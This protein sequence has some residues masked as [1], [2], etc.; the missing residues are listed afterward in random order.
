MSTEQQQ[1]EATIAADARRVLEPIEVPSPLADLWEELREVMAALDRGTWFS[2]TLDLVRADGSAAFSYNHDE[3]IRF[4]RLIPELDPA[5][6]DLTS[7]LDESWADELRRHP[8]SPAYVPAWLRE[9][10]G[11]EAVARGSGQDGRGTTPEP[12]VHRTTRTVLPKQEQIEATIAAEARR[13]LEQREWTTARFTVARVGGEG[14]SVGRCTRPDG[15][16]EAIRLRM[17]FRDLWE[18]L[19][20]VM[21][22][23]D[24]GTWFSATLDLDRA[25][26]S[27]AFSYNHDERIW[28]D[29]LIPDLD[30]ADL[31]LTVPLDE[32]W[33]DELRRHPRSPEYVPAWLRA[34]VGSEAAGSEPEDG[35]AVER[36]I[37][38]APTWPPSRAGLASSARWSAVFDAVSEEIVRALRA[39][40][41][42]TE[43]LR[44]E[45]DDRALEQVA[46][47]ATNALLTRFVEDES[48]CAALAAE[49]GSS[50][51]PEGAED[52][53]TDAITDLVDWQLARRF[54][55]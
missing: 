19:R 17:P 29:R 43:L 47:T 30:P 39:E 12:D 52:D 44:R 27:A 34:L 40:T 3:R 23:P 4:D 31:H 1:I 24:R 35:A 42:A 15:S 22:E 11:G 36:A 48:A 28:F 10:V 9:L 20:E 51:G 21:N 50:N 6:M 55:R 25:D 14:T 16:L 32:S 41:P 13:L 49:L 33:A 54:E 53:V 26:G 2:A 5:D 7:P 18:E 37:G 45:V 46:E 38:V 8:R